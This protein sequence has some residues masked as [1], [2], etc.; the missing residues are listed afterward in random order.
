MSWTATVLSKSSD[1]NGNQIVGLHF[2]DGAGH[3]YDVNN[4][5]PFGAP[6]TQLADFTADM[7]TK[8]TAQQTVMSAAP[9][10]GSTVTPT[11]AAATD[12]NATTKATFLADYL[13]L[14]QY[15]AAISHGL[16]TN[17]DL[18]YVAQLAKVVGEFAA[19]KAILLPLVDVGP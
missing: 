19:N 18:T 1:T 14:K 16:L 7:I 3:T 17:L 2:D 10:V 5:I 4:F 12:Q 9:S 6:S 13:L 15:Q 11:P 8:L